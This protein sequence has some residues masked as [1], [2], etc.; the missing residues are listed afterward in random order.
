MVPVLFALAVA[1]SASLEAWLGPGLDPAPFAA[2]AAARAGDP[3][4]GAREPH[5]TW[6][7]SLLRAGAGPLRDWAATRLM[8]SVAAVPPQAGFP[9]PSGLLMDAAKARLEREVLWGN[10]GERARTASPWDPPREWL[11]L[12]GI[13][14][15]HPEA[16]CWAQWRAQLKDVGQ[17]TVSMGFYALFAP[18]LQPGDR[19]WVLAA[20]EAA[21]ARNPQAGPWLSYAFLLATDWLM[22]Y[23]HEEHWKAFAAACA[24]KAWRGELAALEKEAKTIKGFWAGVPGQGLVNPALGPSGHGAGYRPPRMTW[25]TVLQPDYPEREGL[26][27]LGDRV[28][29]EVGIDRE[30]RQERL[31]LVPGYALG[32][33]GPC[34]LRWVARWSFEAASEDGRPVPGEFLAT[35]NFVSKP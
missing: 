4:A 17:P 28:R 3:S 15:M 13:A 30:G 12:G 25:T 22:L 10:Q 9:H 5:R 11:G 7:L 23:G 33:F 16:P 29:V 27:G 26:R 1:P 14:D 20:L 32:V 6:L 18:R 19:P 24:P 34:A 31:A 21:A 2:F 8:E 35:V